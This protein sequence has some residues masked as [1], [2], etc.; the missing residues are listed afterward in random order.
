MRDM[1]MYLIDRHKKFGFQE[2]E[3]VYISVMEHKFSVEFAVCLTRA[4]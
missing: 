2:G 3:E 4:L 1:Y